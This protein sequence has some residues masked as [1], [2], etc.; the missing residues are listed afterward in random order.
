[1]AF[2]IPFLAGVAVI[3]AGLLGAGNYLGWFGDEVTE[4]DT[5]TIT[6][7]V[8]WYESPIVIISIIISIVL[9]IYIMRK[10]K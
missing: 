10:P 6:E 4:I 1:M 8:P 3:S 9:L 5:I 7:S 2:W